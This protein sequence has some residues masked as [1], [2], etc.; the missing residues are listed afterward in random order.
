MGCTQ[1]RPTQSSPPDSLEKL[2][3]ENGYVI[4]GRV[5]A[6]RSTGQRHYTSNV[7]Q[8]VRQDIRLAGGGNPGTARTSVGSR[9]G[10]EKRITGEGMK[11]TSDGGDEGG[12]YVKSGRSSTGN[13]GSQEKK[14]VNKEREIL[15][16]NGGDGNVTRATSSAK[17]DGDDGELVDGWPKWLTDNIPGDALEGITPRS[18]DTYDK[19][20]KVNLSF[21]C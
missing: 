10:Q 8:Y 4:G 19:I 17:S 20:D 21:Y 11:V 7:G 15:S 1:G 12:K 3:M 6:R 2:K 18:A 13:R 5:A 14:P 16:A 9:E